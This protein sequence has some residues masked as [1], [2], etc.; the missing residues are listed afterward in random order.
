M[1]KHSIY[2]VG[3]VDCDYDEYIGFVVSASSKDEARELAVEAA[4]KTNP[5]AFQAA[6]VTKVGRSDEQASRVILDSF[7]AG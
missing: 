5:G 6:K 1:S 2:L 4:A 7:R 3:P